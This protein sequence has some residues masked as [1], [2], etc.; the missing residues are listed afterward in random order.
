MRVRVNG[1]EREVGEGLTLAALLADL[2]LPAGRVAIERNRE[3]VRRDAYASTR[4][5]DGDV[6]E[7]VQ[8]VGG[9]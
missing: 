2:G 4:L 9:G 8:I 3:I 1:A 7:I 5:A 6:L